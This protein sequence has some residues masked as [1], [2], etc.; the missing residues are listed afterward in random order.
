MPRHAGPYHASGPVS[1]SNALALRS[2]TITPN[3]IAAAAYGPPTAVLAY[4]M[5]RGYP[6]GAGRAMPKVAH[7]HPEPAIAYIPAK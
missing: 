7:R 5:A 3:P 1:R 2:G 4:A 6:P